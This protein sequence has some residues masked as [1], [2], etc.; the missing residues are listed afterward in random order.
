MDPL[1]DMPSFDF[2]RAAQ[3]DDYDREFEENMY[4]IQNTQKVLQKRLT[5]ADP[6]SNKASSFKG[7]WT[8]FGDTA[9]SKNKG[10]SKASKSVNSKEPVLNQVRSS[11][12]KTDTDY[13]PN[14]RQ[15]TT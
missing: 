7:N 13:M 5:G 6:V 8:I 9:S 14:A 4:A 11:L 3:I 12:V 10:N 15:T 2:N 1:E